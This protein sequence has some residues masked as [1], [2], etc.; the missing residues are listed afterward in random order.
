MFVADVRIH[1]TGPILVGVGLMTTA[2][3]QWKVEPEMQQ[4]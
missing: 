2:N 1:R 4:S 3:K